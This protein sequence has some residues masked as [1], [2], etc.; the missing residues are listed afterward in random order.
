MDVRKIKENTFDMFPVGTTVKVVSEI[1]DFRFF[2]LQTGIVVENTGG[3]LGI[4]VQFDEPMNYEDGSVL[5]GYGFNPENLE[6]ISARKTSTVEIKS[7]E[8]KYVDKL[9]KLIGIRNE[10]WAKEA[11]KIFLEYS[12][13]NRLV[14]SLRSK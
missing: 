11:T 5:K 14:E 13:E 1:V 9:F 10:Y 8:E 2:Y 12:D 3:Y 4:R 6:V 7:L